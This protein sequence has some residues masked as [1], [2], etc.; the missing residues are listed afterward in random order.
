M[1]Q[2]LAAGLDR[3]P[4][5]AVLLAL[6]GVDLGWQLSWH[7]ELGQVEELPTLE[8]RAVGEVEV[9]G[10]CVVGPAAGVLD[11]PAAPDAGGAV[12]VEETAAALTSRVLDH[13]V[14]VEQDR[15]DPGQQR[16]VAVQVT[17][18]RLHHAHFGIGEV[19]HGLPEE[20]RVGHKIGVENR[21]QLAASHLE[22]GRQG[23]GLEA[24]PV[25]TVEVMNVE[26]LGGEPPDLAVQDLPCL[27][28]RIVKDLDFQPIPGIIQAADG[29]HKAL[30]HVHL[31]ED[32]KL[33]G[34][35]WPLFRGF[36]LWQ[37]IKTRAPER[38]QQSPHGERRT[39]REFR[40]PGNR[41]SGPN[42]TSTRSSRILYLFHHRCA[43][44]ALLVASF[45]ALARRATLLRGRW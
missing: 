17:P 2:E 15:L 25:R 42:P 7:D 19:G 28:D 23:P 6:V 4:C 24:V 3:A 29:L 14:A 37:S 41:V 40:E 36:A 20:F 12:E 35:D 27:V 45:G 22:P 8:L 9:F 38:P 5:P 11:R 32:R 34:H 43:P 10:Q 1:G 30:G 26:A 33:D 13:E 16:I 39:G 44:L 21:H 18:A 31:V